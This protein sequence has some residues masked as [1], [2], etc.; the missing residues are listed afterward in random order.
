MVFDI[1]KNCTTI[2]FNTCCC[3]GRCTCNYVIPL[4]ARCC[5][6]SKFANLEPLHPTPHS[7]TTST[8]NACPYLPVCYL[9]SRLTYHVYIPISLSSMHMHYTTCITCPPLMHASQPINIEFQ[10]ICHE[11]K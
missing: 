3:C 2:Y 7:A 1:T 9:P 11:M 8:P 4:T 5:F 6:R 10:T